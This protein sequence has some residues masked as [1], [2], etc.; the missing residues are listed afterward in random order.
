MLHVQFSI[1][2]SPFYSQYDHFMEFLQDKQSGAV[3]KYLIR[4]LKSQF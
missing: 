1:G 2:Q 3:R 4:H